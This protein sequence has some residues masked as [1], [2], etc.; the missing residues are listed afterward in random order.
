VDGPSPAPSRP[1]PEPAGRG[2]PAPLRALLAVPLFYK[3]LVANAAVVVLAVVAAAWAFARLAGPREPYGLPWLVLLAALGA[4]LSVAVN[5]L[6]VRLALRPLRL[7]EE[8]A[9]RVQAGDLD[10]RAP[11]SP[12]ADREQERLARTF[13]GMLDTLASY[14]RRLRDVAVR[15]LG[16]AEAERAR[17]ARELHDDTA[18]TLAAVLIR[19]RLLR[20][21]Q[22]EEQ[23]ART[24]EEVRAELAAALEGVRRYARGLRPPAL[25]DLGLVPAITSFAASLQETHGIHIG[26]T[27][28]PAFSESKLPAETE[29]ALYRIV[30]E[31]LW[32][33]A[34]HAGARR[35]EV[36]LS[37]EGADARVTVNDDGCGFDVAAVLARENE[38]LGLFGMRERAAYSGGDVLID[39]APGRGTTIHVRVPI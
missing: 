17:I 15:A 10:A 32:N 26:V 30:Q 38:G 2:A 8:A 5:A 29:L 6:L 21:D 19:L 18:Q 39:S 28:D 33:V 4:A 7:L 37:R 1:A 36:S 34:R 24:L 25:D 13:N 31:A 11:S 9:V 12:L 35:A 16:A 23:R 20:A 22:P 27:A 3:L 14:R